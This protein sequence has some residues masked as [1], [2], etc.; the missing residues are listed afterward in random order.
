MNLAA[1]L[2]T[3]ACAAVVIVL[4]QRDGRM[5]GSGSPVL[6]IPLIWMFLAGSRW[7]SAWLGVSPTLGTVQSYAEGSPLDRTVFAALMTAAAF[8]LW[9]RRL[10]WAAIF[11]ANRWLTVYLIYCAVSALW[12]DDA[13]L[14]FKR[15]LKDMGGPLMALVILTD[16][17]PAQA[18]RIVL[19]RLALLW[20]PLS[21]LFIRYFPDWGRVFHVDGMPMYT[22][23]GQ[24]KNDLG[25]ICLETGLL[26]AWMWLFPA[27]KSSSRA[28]LAGPDHG[29]PEVQVLRDRWVLLV[30]GGLTLWLLHLS[31]SRTALGCLIL[32]I[33]TLSALRSPKLAAK[34]LRIVGGLILLAT[35]TWLL[36]ASLDLR[37]T[38][39]SLMG[40]DSSLTNRTSLWKLLGSIST[41]PWWGEGY[42]SFWSGWRMQTVW[43]A[44]GRG[45]NQAHSGY[46]E[47]FLNLGWVGVA[48]ILVLAWV[49]IQQALKSLPQATSWSA[50][51]MTIVGVILLYN[52][53]E[54]AFYGINTLWVL[55]LIS[56]IQVQP[57]W[58]RG[59]RRVSAS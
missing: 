6:W 58:V 20:L 12:A 59:L 41:N 32:G 16:R 7:V 17:H 21:A 33:L 54:A 27:S 57:A 42:M 38:T 46:L 50:W 36:D 25:L 45:I 2:A 37:S 49:S 8:V 11:S 18:L 34:P 40:R 19:T 29:P 9:R 1:L 55:F 39:L 35:V 22:G 14:S 52:Y 31:N 48:F 3:V 30:L 4:W 10:Q 23:V 44:L 5:N 13:S 56:L 24:Q 28:S 51:R 53:T 26:V 43:N 47:Q 15:W